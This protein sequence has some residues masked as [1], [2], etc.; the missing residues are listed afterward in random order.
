MEIADRIRHY[1]KQLSLSQTQLAEISGVNIK[2]LSR[3]ENGSSVPPADALKKLADAMRVS[4]DALLD[5]QIEAIKD[6]DLYKLF[7]VIQ[8]MEGEDKNTVVNF[9]NMAARDFKAKQAY[10]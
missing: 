8:N 3:Y 7:L 9:L 2:S 5:D 10:S 1:R 6:K 4:A